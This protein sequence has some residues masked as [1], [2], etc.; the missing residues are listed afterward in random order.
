MVE[1]WS[2]FIHSL[3][4]TSPRATFPTKQ[5]ST[6]CVWPKLR[7]MLLAVKK[8]PELQERSSSF[9]TRNGK[10]ILRSRETRE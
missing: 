4:I 7:S 9:L 6:A 5:L 10:V 1:D 8:L 3:S 2:E